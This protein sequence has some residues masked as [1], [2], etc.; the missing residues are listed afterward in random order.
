MIVLFLAGVPINI[1]IVPVCQI[2]VSMNWLSMIP[3][4]MFLGVTSLP[5]VLFIIKNAIDAIPLD[6]EEAARIEGANKARILWR[7]V[8]PLAMPGIAALS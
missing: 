1:V 7:V 5:F 2:F 3:T 6:L 8:V 4:A